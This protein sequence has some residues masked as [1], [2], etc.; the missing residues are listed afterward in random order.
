[1]GN[2]VVHFEI[3]GPDPEFSAK[4]YSELFGWNV[5][6]APGMEDYGVIETGG[7]SGING[8]MGKADSAYESVVVEVPD[9]QETLDRAGQLGA[10]TTMPVTDIPGVVTYAQFADPDGNRIGLVL[11]GDQG[12]PAPQASGNPPVTWFEIYGREPKSLWP[13]YQE[14][15][16]W[17]IK[18]QTGA[19]MI[20]GEVDTGGDRGIKGGI[21]AN[22]MNQPG[23]MIYAETNDLQE[24]LD[25][26]LALGA[27]TL[28][29]PMQVTDDVAVSVFMDPQGMPTGLY[30]Q[31]R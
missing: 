16:G 22:P 11:G 9:L 12:G 21:L 15:F 1:M 25:R 24:Y 14:L 30:K 26:A 23:V 17:T 3:N 8:G 27:T 6:F 7:G 10:K 18:E 4:F 29:P 31:T 20:Y 5:Q 28:M 13:F 2:P 19:Q